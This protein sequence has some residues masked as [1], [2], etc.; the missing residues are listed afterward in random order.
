MSSAE[1]FTQNAKRYG[2]TYLQMQIRNKK[3]AW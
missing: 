3:S 1:F 2:F